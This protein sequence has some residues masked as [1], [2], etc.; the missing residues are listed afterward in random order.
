MTRCRRPAKTAAL[1]PAIAVVASVAAGLAPAPT[2]RLTAQTREHGSDRAAVEAALRAYR[3][4]WL[5]NDAARVMATIT[6]DAVIYP[7]SL[8]PISG[9]AAIRAFWF[10]AT[11]PA[12]TV[13]AMTVTIEDVH[14]D[15]DTAIA[16]GSG[17]LTFVLDSAAANAAPRTQQSWHVNVLKRQPDGGWR[18]WRRMWGDHAAPRS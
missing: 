1:L 17:S 4:A 12:T 18:I 8:R 9:A 14:V 5:A 10:P 6:P 2:V 15:G 16:S 11:G 7:S 3:E 13:L